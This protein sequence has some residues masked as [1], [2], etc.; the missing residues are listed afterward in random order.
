MAIIILVI[1]QW[2]FYIKLAIDAEGVDKMWFIFGLLVPLIAI[3]G[4]IYCLVKFE[5]QDLQVWESVGENNNST[6]NKP[7]NSPNLSF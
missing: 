2:D 4:I 1:V 5:Q 3:I 7:D 6:K